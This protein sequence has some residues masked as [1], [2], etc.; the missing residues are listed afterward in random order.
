MTN[1]HWRCSFVNNKATKQPK[2][3]HNHPLC[4]PG[5]ATHITQNRTRFLSRH[6]DTILS[7]AQNSKQTHSD[8]AKGLN[9]DH[10]GAKIRKVDVD[11]LV[12]NW[13][14]ML[15]GSRTATQMFLQTLEEMAA[16][17]E[18]WYRIY[19]CNDSPDGRIQRV[20]WTYRWSVDKWQQNPEFLS[21]NNT[22]K[23]NRFNMP[24]CLIS[25]VDAHHGTFPVAYALLSGEKTQSFGWVLSQLRSC[26]E[27]HGGITAAAKASAPATPA[28]VHEP[29]VIISDFD[30][31]FK[32]AARVFYPSTVKHQM[33]VW[34]ILKNVAWNIK[35]KWVGSLE[36][37]LLGERGGG[38]GS[39][40]PGEEVDG[41]APSPPTQDSSRAA[42]AFT[43]DADEDIVDAKAGAIANTLLSAGDRPGDTSEHT[44]SPLARRARSG[45]GTRDYVNDA[46]GI[47]LAWR[48][49]VYADTEE[50]FDERWAKLQSEFAEQPDIV[51]Y[52]DKIYIPWR[53]Q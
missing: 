10:P 28:W 5:D 23:V 7:R 42:Q 33:C 34:H 35:K 21:I 3:T 53:D 26:G 31:A 49:C 19:R 6:Q 22:Y 47:L 24:L 9:N 44:N 39:A 8:I 14:R 2:N 38:A 32:H 36:G 48:D 30:R 37:T 52:L 29:F 12:Y 15:Y 50:D 1:G 45:T 27:S 25:G 18:I 13:K 17:E 51:E 20:F 43:D 4:D 46:D 41:P 16:K 40:D 11:N